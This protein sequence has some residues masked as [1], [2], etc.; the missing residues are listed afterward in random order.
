MTGDSPLTVTVSC[1]VATRSVHVDLGVEAQGDAD[2]VAL[3]GA[4][5]GELVG[6]RVLAGRHGGE[7]VD[8][9]LVG[10][11]RERAGLGRAGGGDGDAG[12]HA[13]LFV[14]HFTR[15]T[16][17]RTRAAALRKR[18]R[19]G[20]Q[21]CG[22]QREQCSAPTCHVNNLLWGG[23]AKTTRPAVA[24]AR[25]KK[26]AAERP[27]AV[28]RADHRARAMPDLHGRRG[29]S[30]AWRPASA[31]AGTNAAMPWTE[32]RQFWPECPRSCRAD[33]PESGR[34]ERVAPAQRTSS[35]SDAAM[36]GGAGPSE[37]FGF[38]GEPIQESGRALVIAGAGSG[39]GS[40]S[41]VT[42]TIGGQP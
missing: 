5:A 28:V 33:R 19:G 16:A 42:T 31:P 13:A 26:A 30:P 12:Q 3:D 24:P 36:S 34:P 22:C 21:H 32:C 4:E 7:A 6:E 11:R 15:D 25:Q 8:A 41:A 37:Y 2:A 35:V 1:R 40:G 27:G 10:D 29:A 17:G 20:Q 23:R 14:L 38:L 18:A 9:R 39:N